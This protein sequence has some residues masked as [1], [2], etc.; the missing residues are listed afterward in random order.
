[1]LVKSGIEGVS[2]GEPV[3][4]VRIVIGNCVRIKVI[5]K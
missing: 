4:Q 2:V 3:K 1:M 5:M